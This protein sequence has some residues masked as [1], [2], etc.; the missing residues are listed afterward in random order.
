VGRPDDG[1][2]IAELVATLSYAADLG[3]GQP[4]DHCLRQ[5][6]IALRLAD[7]VGADRPQREATYYL[8]LMIGAYCHA[9]A[10]EQASWFGDDIEF[11]ATGF[12]L[13]D[14]DTA[15]VVGTILRRLSSHGTGIE[16]VRRIAALPVTARSRLSHFL[17]THATIGAQMAGRLGLAPAVQAAV[18]QAYEQ[19][20][21]KGFP[22]GLRGED[23]CLATRVVPVAGAIEIF[24]R[25][26]GTSG[27][28][29]VV[30][31]HR[32]GQ[33]DPGVVDAFCDHAD[34]VLDGLDEAATWDAVLDLEPWPHRCVDGP[35]LDAALEAIADGVDLKSPHLAG[36]SRG[37]ALLAA[38]AAR[39]WG[40]GE[41]EVTTVRRAGL[42]HD[43]GRLGV[44]NAV[45]DKPGPL[46]EAERERVRLHPYLTN[47]MLARVTALADSRVI[48]SRHHERLDGSGYPQGLTAGSLSPGDRLLAAADSYHAMTEPRPF[49]NACPEEAAGRQLL[50]EVAAGRLDPDA[51]SAVLMAAGHRAP[52][53]HPRP[54]GLTVREVEVLQLIARG[55][56]NKE[57]ARLLH[58]TPKTASNH[59]EHIYTKLGVTSRAAATLCAIQ[60]HLVGSFEPA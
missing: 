37:V 41:A 30:R 38:E 60:H 56:T 9:D 34:T 52:I 46:T 31:R 18:G 19:W 54:A 7:L 50:D 47:R 25:R 10:A 40:L 27:A 6:V 11:K 43:L 29:E 2:R 4:M 39:V 24:G 21:G 42:V 33:Y 8:G 49:R 55:H 36:H 3:L 16:R 51:V 22:R 35:E 14:M 58:V 48:A 20:D 1:V 32:G 15:Q 44:S 59:V 57:I 5:T 53:H 17:E 13:L 23:I 45:W 12:E 26:R 28:V